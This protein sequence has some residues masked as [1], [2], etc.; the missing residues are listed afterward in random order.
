ME[1]CLIILI[2]VC[3]PSTSLCPSNKLTYSCFEYD[4]ET[5]N[6]QYIFGENIWNYLF[7]NIFEIN[8]IPIYQIYFR[9]LI[10][11]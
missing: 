8:I 9:M 6:I 7:Q 10:V 1:Q 4:R 5:D 3:T 11:V 2:V